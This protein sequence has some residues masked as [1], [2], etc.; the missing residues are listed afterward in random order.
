MLQWCLHEVHGPGAT[1][2]VKCNK[3][4]VNKTECC[5]SHSLHIGF[6]KQSVV[7]L[8]AC[9]CARHCITSNLSSSPNKTQRILD[10]INTGCTLKAVTSITVQGVYFMS[11]KKEKLLED[12]DRHKCVV[13]RVGLCALHS[14]QKSA[15]L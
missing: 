1:I 8:C 3:R 4:P 12:V 5:Q 6:S 10:F 14:V 13:K 11:M 2:N 9:L 15:L 7:S